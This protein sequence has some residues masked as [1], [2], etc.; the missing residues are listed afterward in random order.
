MTKKIETRKDEIRLTTSSPEKMFGQYLAKPLKRTWTEE[1]VDDDTSEVI[2]IERS[3]MIVQ[4]GTYIDNDILSRIRFHIDSG[5]ITAVEVSNQQRQAHMVSYTG[6]TPWSVTA[7]VG[8]KKHKILLYANSIEMAMEVV[9]DFIELNFRETF[10]LLNIRD[11]NDCIIIKDNLRKVTAEDPDSEDPETQIDKKFYK[12]EVK[13]T[14]ESGSY[15]STYIVHTTDVDS[16]MISIN[17]WLTD[18][19]SKRAQ[20]R[21]EQEDLDFITAIESAVVIPCSCTIDREFSAAYLNSNQ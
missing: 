16:A 20:E 5:D 4:Q 9:K 3:E 14:R 8:K 7:Q 1:F 2:P 18:S 15:T 6:L 10:I 17:N 21:N 11:Y 12:I 19:I 13:V